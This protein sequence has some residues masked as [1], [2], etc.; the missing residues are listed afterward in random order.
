[1]N[2]QSKKCMQNRKI[3]INLNMLIF[4]VNEYR[5]LRTLDGK[6]GSK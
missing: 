6:K 4:N 1:M 2:E 3:K 5:K